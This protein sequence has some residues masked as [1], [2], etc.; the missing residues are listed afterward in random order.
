MGDQ[1]TT[2]LGA[3]PDPEPDGGG[4][5]PGPRRKNL[6]LVVGDSGVPLSRAQATGARVARVALGAN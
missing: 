5:P 2:P 6:V 4:R 3:G 1:P